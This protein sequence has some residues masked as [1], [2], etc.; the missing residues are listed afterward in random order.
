MSD[1]TNI[2]LNQWYVDEDT[3]ERFMYTRLQTIPICKTH[4][5]DKS[6]ACIKCP[7]V[8]MG[9][10]GNLHIQKADGIY[11]RKDNKRIA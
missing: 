8:F 6:H 1:A 2:Q 9:F 5:F 7:Y 10:R 3:Q 11:R 4:E